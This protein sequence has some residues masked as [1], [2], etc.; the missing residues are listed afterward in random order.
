MLKALIKKQFLELKYTFLRD[1]KTGKIKTGKA[2]IGF[3]LLFLLVGFS[4]AMMF[5]ENAAAFGEVILAAH[6]DWLL[7]ALNG[8][9]ALAAVSFMTMFMT[10]A[11]VYSAKDN[12]LLLAMPI[13]PSYIVFARLLTVYVLALAYSTVCY[14]PA[15][16]YYGL[17]GKLTVLGFIYSFIEIALI[18]LVGLVVS[19]VLAFF[20]SL[21][22]KVFKKRAY[23]SLVFTLLFLG[24]YYYFTFNMNKFLTALALNME[25]VT[26]TVARKVWIFWQFGKAATGDTKAFLI[27][28]AICLAFFALSYYIISRTFIKSVTMTFD[29]K[30]KAY[31]EKKVAKAGIRK[32]LLLKEFRRWSTCSS[33]LTNTFFGSVLLIAASVFLIVKKNMVGEYLDVILGEVPVLK[34]MLPVIIIGVLAYMTVLDAVSTPSVSLEG[35][36]FWVLR[37]LPIK[38]M[39]IINAKRNFELLL[40]SIPAFIFTV[41]AIFV[42]E[43]DL[44][45][46]LETLAL[47]VILIAFVTYFHLS[48]G[49]R[50]ANLIWTSE[51]VPVKQGTAMMIVVFAG[52][53]IAVAIPGIYFLLINVLNPHL[54]IAILAVVLIAATVIMDRWIKR[55][56]VE[57]F[58]HL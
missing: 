26:K 49:I 34:T 35:K 41:T 29:T 28:L 18:A 3:V 15:I 14:G 56:G 10:T 57:I 51:I 13:R 42:F 43:F 58:E 5:Y 24:V 55:K 40:S 1:K 36:S 25:R 17:E 53:A 54:Y 48:M 33:Y 2:A 12:E 46:T 7:F 47:S 23:L 11:S 22:N 20:M 21:L 8:M 6:N 50:F 37:S 45:G 44:V 39:D 38:T 4:F 9:T 32:A 30:K 31:K 52:M 19:C 16:L 27:I